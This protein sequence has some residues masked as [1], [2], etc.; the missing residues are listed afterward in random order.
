MSNAHGQYNAGI[1]FLDSTFYHGC[2]EEIFQCW[3]SV[4]AVWLVIAATLA[5]NT[6]EP[7]K[8]GIGR[9]PITW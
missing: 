3:S 6:V 8:R 4:D 9:E 2:T 1:S 5:T 7:D